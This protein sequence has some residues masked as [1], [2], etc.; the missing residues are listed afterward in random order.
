MVVWAL[1]AKVIEAIYSRL[2]NEILLS[3]SNVQ[4]HACEAVGKKNVTMHD[5]NRIA[6]FRKGRKLAKPS[7]E[8]DEAPFFIFY[9]RMMEASNYK[10]I[11]AFEISL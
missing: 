7:Q 8:W 1:G 4:F 3:T 6:N 5:R 2:Y 10:T 9:L 11:R